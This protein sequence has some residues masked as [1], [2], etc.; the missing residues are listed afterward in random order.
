M[1]RTHT[2]A[3]LAIAASAAVAMLQPLQASA[4][5]LTGNTKLG[6]DF[7]LSLVGAPVTEL[8]SG[9]I[10]GGLS[11]DDG[12]TIRISIFESEG[13]QLLGSKDVSNGFGFS[14]ANIGDSLLLATP[15]LADGIGFAVYE[16][17]NGSF[18][19][20]AGTFNSFA[21]T[22]QTN[23]VTGTNLHV[24]GRPD[25][26]VPEPAT[27]GLLMAAAMAAAAAARARKPR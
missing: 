2:L 20:T 8:G 14:I 4:L 9:V 24:L 6:I 1:K 22:A 21:P 18:D 15:G 26:Q 13:G 12:E 3:A 16:A 17:V 19:V 25:N 7:N 11:F 27:L 23:G 10:F 5:A